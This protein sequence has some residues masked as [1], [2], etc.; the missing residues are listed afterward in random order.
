MK[1]V[2]ICGSMRFSNEMQ[3]IAFDLET[4]HNMNVLQCIYNTDDRVITTVTN[5]M[6]N[7]PF[8]YL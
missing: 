8:V 7:N 5:V 6:S 2:T 3:R 1:T 4:K